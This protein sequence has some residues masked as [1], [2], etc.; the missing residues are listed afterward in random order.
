M[1]CPALF[2]RAGLRHGGPEKL[3]LAPV[4]PYTTNLPTAGV[5]VSVAKPATK[6]GECLHRGIWEQVSP[7]VRGRP[8]LTQTPSLKSCVL[9][10]P[11]PLLTR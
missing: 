5:S 3:S 4:S 9:H 6:E 10:P 1:S 11:G 8:H 7:R 2:T